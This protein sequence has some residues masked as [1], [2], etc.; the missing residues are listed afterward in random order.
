MTAVDVRELEVE[1][2]S[3]ENDES[4]ILAAIETHSIDVIPDKERHGTIRQQGVFWF[5]SNTQTLSVAVGFIGIALGLSVW[6]TIIAVLL[7]NAF[8]TVFMALHAS[9]G[10]RLGLPQMIQSRAQFGYRG[11]VL[12]LFLA[13]FTYLIFAVLDTVIIAQG[14]NQIFGW[15]TVAV[16]VVIA[17]AAV[18][19]AVYGYDWLHRAF[20]VLFWASLPLWLVLTI[21]ILTGNAGGKPA[22]H[23]TFGWIA[24]FVVFA[25]SASNNI[26]YAPVVSDYSRYL[27]RSTPFGKVV[28]SV[29]VGAFLSLSWLAAIG[30]W[31]AAHL[32]ATDAL[33]TVQQAGNHIASGFG[34][35]LIIVV[36][37]ALV[38]TMGEMAYSGQLVVLT[39]IDS[40]RP[41]R[42]T[43]TKRVVTASL[44][45][46]VWAI[47]G[48]AVFHNVTTAVDDGLTLSLYLL[49]PWTIVNLYDYFFVRNG[50]YAITELEN[51]R[52]LYGVWGWR[53]IAAYVIGFAASVPFW[54]L[55]FYVSPV[56]NA[57]NGL[58]IS[59]IVELFVSGALYVIFARSIDLSGDAAT[60]E[61]S[62]A[63]LVALG[64]LQPGDRPSAAAHP[65]LARW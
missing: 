52:G 20:R 30:A 60:I 9:Q 22:P 27:P 56:A 33:T 4:P 5:L 42:P 13:L 19:L 7:G 54:D 36:T 58:D 18:L 39:A 43:V 2:A 17:I 64:I 49:T 51:R 8:G 29:Y 31:L 55:S 16:G 11:V 10:P 47:L 37:I 35:A 21:G 6:W 15:N 40:I 63:A 48:L 46:T 1:Q 57:T 28:T 53:G 3:P 12:P 50:K 45:A 61:A 59:F 38:A 44:I 14:F 41:I 65:A 25:A 24:F 62:N 23:S 32:G 26:S 34:T